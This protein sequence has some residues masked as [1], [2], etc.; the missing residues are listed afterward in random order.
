MI[1]SVK[2]ELVYNNPGFFS[3]DKF[4]VLA[5][6]RSFNASAARENKTRRK[7]PPRKIPV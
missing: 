6:E 5:I 4:N 1:D 2:Q 7:D 3:F